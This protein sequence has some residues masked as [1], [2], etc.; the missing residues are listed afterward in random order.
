MIR[1]QGFRGA[2]F[3]TLAEGDLRRNA[4]NRA[5]VSEILGVSPAWAYLNQVHGDGIIE[6]VA[7]GLQGDGD[8]MF[9][10]TRDLPLVVGTADC[11]PVIL[12]GAGVVAVIH[13]GWRGAVAGVVPATLEAVAQSGH[14]IERAA[15]GPA[16]GPRCYEVGDEVATQFPDFVRTTSWGTQSIDLPGSI[17]AQLEPLPVWQ[18]GVCTYSS[19]LLASH[20]RDGTP[21]RQA[22]VA[23]LPKD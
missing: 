1:P 22:A 15:I 9:T 10:T 16:I 6:V 20:R 18:A 23:W 21:E 7:A 11:V 17:V 12:E 8:A 2:A 19:D 14:T 13:A 5:R 3:G 4:E